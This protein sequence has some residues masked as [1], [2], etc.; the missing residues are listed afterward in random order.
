MLAYSHSFLSEGIGFHIRL[1][2]ESLFYQPSLFLGRVDVSSQNYPLSSFIALSFNVL[3]RN[4]LVPSLSA[5]P[6]I[7]WSGEALWPHSFPP[8]RTDF[9]HIFWK[10]LLAPFIVLP[11]HIF[12]SCDF[13]KLKIVLYHPPLLCHSIFWATP[14]SKS[15]PNARAPSLITL[16]HQLWSGEA[17]YPHSFLIEGDWSP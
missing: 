17:P 3:L 12:G 10:S 9:L 14:F 7:L 2:F 1:S 6:S 15:L 8:K 11:F 16:Y 5:R 13:F 4:S